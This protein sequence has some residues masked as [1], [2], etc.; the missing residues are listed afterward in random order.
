MEKLIFNAIEIREFW[1]YCAF[2]IF[3][4]YLKAAQKCISPWKTM[5]W[6]IASF[7]LH[8]G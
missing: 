6:E 3:A 2:V 4:L 7:L 8:W 5:K 1:K